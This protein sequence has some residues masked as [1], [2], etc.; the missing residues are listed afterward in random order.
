MVVTWYSTPD[1]I[2][3]VLDILYLVLLLATARS[4]LLPVYSFNGEGLWIPQASGSKRVCDS[5]RLSRL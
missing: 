4:D 5:K 3:L 1:A 2:P